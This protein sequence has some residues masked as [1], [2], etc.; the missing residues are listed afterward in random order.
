VVAEAVASGLFTITLVIGVAAA[1]TTAVAVVLLLSRAGSR[2]DSTA[3]HLSRDR[4]SGYMLDIAD[5]GSHCRGGSGHNG[6]RRRATI[7]V[8]G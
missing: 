1:V 5:S 7:V 6:C 2:L 3:V 4:A 8:R